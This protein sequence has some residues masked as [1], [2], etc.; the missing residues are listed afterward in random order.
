MFIGDVYPVRL[1]IPRPDSQSRLTNF[2]FLGGLV[3]VFLLTPHLLVLTFLSIAGFLVYFVASFAI[4]FTGRYPIG[5]FNFSV[6]VTRWSADVF[7]YWSH[8]H[9]V[10]PPFSMQAS[11][12]HIQLEVDYSRGSNRL[13]NLPWLGVLVKVT[14]LIPH[15]VVLEFLILTVLVIT[16][17]AEFTILL[18]GTYPKGLHAFVVGV[19]RWL[20]RT[21]AHAFALT[22][23]Y[24]PFAFE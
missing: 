4:L 22:D 17:L 16:L 8:L 18:T 6:G 19:K 10:Y 24:P 1:E 23:R 3:R 20:T 15:L 11:E 5:L 9:D 13:L 21:N 7:A 12:S 14:L 2:P